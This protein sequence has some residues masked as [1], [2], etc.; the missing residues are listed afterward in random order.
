MHKN[1][2]KTKEKGRKG[3]MEKQKDRKMWQQNGLKEGH[4]GNYCER[5]RR[6]PKR[7]GSVQL[8]GRE[9]EGEV[10]F[11]C[12]CLRSEQID[13]YTGTFHLYISINGSILCCSPAP[14]QPN[15]IHVLINPSASFMSAAIQLAQRQPRHYTAELVP[16]KILESSTV[17]YRTEM[18][19]ERI[20]HYGSLLKNSDLPN[21]DGQ[22]G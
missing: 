22:K 13:A 9:E 1:I 7:K 17:I 20:Q 18:C 2:R 15:K 14:S 16:L 12:V 8:Q 6:K 19:L 10:C 5:R 21:E 4:G 3:G 11:Y